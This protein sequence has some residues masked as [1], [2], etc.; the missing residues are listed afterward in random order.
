MSERQYAVRR[1]LLRLPGSRKSDAGCHSTS[2][3]ATDAGGCTARHE[4]GTLGAVTD[5]A[6]HNPMHY[7]KD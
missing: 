6:S 4:L 2:S 5:D 3:G 7:A 1:I